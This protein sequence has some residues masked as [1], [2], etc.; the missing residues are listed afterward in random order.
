VSNEIIDAVYYNQALSDKKLE[1]LR[2]FTRSVLEANGWVDQK[3]LTAFYQAG[4]NQQQVLEVILGI[5]FK[6]LSNFINQINDT[7]IDREFLSGL[8]ENKITSCCNESA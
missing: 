1:A 5:S 8:P 2:T 6:T 4:Y 7:P 3:S